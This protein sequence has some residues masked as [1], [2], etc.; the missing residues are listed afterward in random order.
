MKQVFVEQ[1][2]SLNQRIYL[3][4]NQ[5]HHLFDVLRTDN[6]ETVRVVGKENNVFLAHPDGKPYLYIFDK[7]EVPSESEHITLCTALIKQDKFE[8]MLQKACELGATRIVPYVS[9]YTVVQLDEKKEQKKLERWSKIILDACKQCNRNDLVE[10]TPIQKVETLVDF[11]SELNLVAYEKEFETGV[12]LAKYLQSNPSSITICIGP[13]G[14]FD[15]AE[16]EL[17]RHDHFQTCSLGSRILRAETAACYILSSIE[18]QKHVDKEV[19]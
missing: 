17:L 4:E 1:D 11:Q 12:H 8:W 13:E 2:L 14:G 16:I 19:L 7:I 9:R 18:Y 5:A 10:L 6:K 3:D 15:D